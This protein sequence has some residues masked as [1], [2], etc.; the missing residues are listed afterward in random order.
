MSK[1]PTSR[2]RCMRFPAP[3]YRNNICVTTETGI[4]DIQFRHKAMLFQIP[5][6]VNMNTYRMKVEFM[7]HD[8][9]YMLQDNTKTKLETK[10]IE[11]NLS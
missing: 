11:V 8:I 1:P 10:Y 7:G 5:L 3:E 4:V 9:W 6:P 2:L